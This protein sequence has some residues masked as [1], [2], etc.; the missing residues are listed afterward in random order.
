M[1]D[2]PISRL[3]LSGLRRAATISTSNL[4]RTELL[5]SG[6][7]LP[8]MLQPNAGDVDLIAWA[9]AN[10]EYLR[11]SLLR[12]GGLLFR[13]FHIGG[14]ARFQ[15]FV[16]AV[17]GQPLEYQEQTSPRNKVY[18]NIYTSTEYPPQHRIFFHNENSYSSTW[19]L[20]IM[21]FCVTAP[22][23]GGET[24]IADVRRVYARIPREIS[25]R[26]ARNGWMLVRNFGT[27]YGLS[28][29]TAFQTDDRDEIS[30]YCRDHGIECEWLS[31]ERLRT[32][33]RRPAMAKHPATGEAVWFNHA[34]FF[35]L[36]TLDPEMRSMLLTELPEEDLPYN[37]YYSDG[38]PIEP[39]VL[40]ILR[41]AYEAESV[42]FPW[43][44]H[45]LL[46]LDNMLVAH[47]RSSFSGPRRILVGMAE[48]YSEPA[49]VCA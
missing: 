43:R 48:P 14:A 13:N 23:G 36:S 27:G 10:R 21:F 29:Q 44:E 49:E 40:D 12:H 17:S 22:A 38:T 34:T 31:S 2:N 11:Q 42:K 33:Q 3:N 28:W 45:D 32:R 4:V 25:E 19:P 26:F 8:L 6:A 1:K 24:P 30:R 41:G 9:A 15:E 39:E 5:E 37:T 35:H 16:Q 7:D 20:K 46:L 47:G 18:G